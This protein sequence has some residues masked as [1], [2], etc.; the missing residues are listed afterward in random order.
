MS[1]AHPILSVFALL[2]LANWNLQ[3][4]SPAA[5]TSWSHLCTGNDLL[6]KWEKAVYYVLNH[7]QHGGLLIAAKLTSH[8]SERGKGGGTKSSQ[9]WM[10]L[11]FPGFSTLPMWNSRTEKKKTNRRS[12]MF[13]IF[14]IDILILGGAIQ[15]LEASCACDVGGA[16]SAEHH[17]MWCLLR[18]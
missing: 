7:N 3:L 10:P 17:W 12:T 1:I 4:K 11:V 2:F 6:G 8:D 16:N 18:R 9:L 5:G 15:D 14:K 13:D